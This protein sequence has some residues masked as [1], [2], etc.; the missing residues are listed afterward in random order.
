MWNT[1]VYPIISS[2]SWKVPTLDHDPSDLVGL[3]GAS[4]WE[5]KLSIVRYIFCVCMFLDRLSQEQQHKSCNFNGH[6][7]SR[8][9][10]ITR[11]TRGAMCLREA[12]V[13]GGD[14]ALMRI[15]GIWEVTHAR[16][17]QQA[18]QLCFIQKRCMLK[19]R[20]VAIPQRQ[21]PPLNRCYPK[22]CCS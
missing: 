5:S 12:V 15:L 17:H 21:L 2:N 10:S 4:V 3:G 7:L 14:T 20:I 18:I 19:L 11:S 9:E 16:D 13:V 1:H 8:R 6:Q 22:W